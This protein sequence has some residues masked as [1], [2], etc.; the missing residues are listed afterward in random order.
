MEGLYRD[1]V[2]RGFGE[3][4]HVEVLFVRGVRGFLGHEA[5][6]REDVRDGEKLLGFQK[7]CRVL[8]YLL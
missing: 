5:C 6:K 1:G 3:G 4:T 7:G 8:S 2:S